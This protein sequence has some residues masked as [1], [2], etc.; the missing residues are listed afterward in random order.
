MKRIAV[1]LLLLCVSL[2]LV[3]RVEISA[4]P[5]VQNN[6]AHVAGDLDGDQTVNNKDVEYLLWHTLFPDTY[7]IEQ[8]ADFDGD[9]AVNN[10]DVEYL[11]WHTLFPDTYPL[12]DA[13]EPTPSGPPAYP[14]LITYEEY[15]AM[16]GDEQMAYYRTF[17]SMQEFNKWYNDAKKDWED[18]HPKETIGPDGTIVLPTSQN[19]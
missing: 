12:E 14:T 9:G 4:V 5:T 17:P 10:K 11:L 15:M 19:T 2:C 18:A 3:A 13:P 7:P 16:T 1:L 6:T 8:N